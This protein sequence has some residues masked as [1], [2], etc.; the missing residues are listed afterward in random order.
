MNAPI[1]QRPG[2]LRNHVV[3]FLAGGV[4]IGLLAG[5]GWYGYRT[6]LAQPFNR[7]LFAGDLDRLRRADLEAL[8]LS[9]QSADRASIETVREAARKVPWVRDAN[10]RRRYPD[11]VEITFEVFHAYARWNDHQLV[12]D[13][14]EV[15]V[16][17]DSTGKLPRLRGPDGSSQL[18]ASELPQV[19]AAL[20]PLGRPLTELRL[21][22]RGAW[23]A[24]LEGG[25]IVAMGR[26]DWR[27]RT[28]RFVDAWPGV[29]ESARTS[30]Y[31]DLRY[32][33]GFALRR[34]ANLTPALPQARGSKTR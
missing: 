2:K 15:F 33:N 7:V 4:V 23:E 8:S 3:P 19:I 25:M 32:P 21:S 13:R 11:A 26:G 1:E 6:V 10:V 30:R 29:S 31:A 14:G 27:P 20:A 22:P 16:A 24:V 34:A 9:V 5:G 18:M 17:E 28:Q 12:N